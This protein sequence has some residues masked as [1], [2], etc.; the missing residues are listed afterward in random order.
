MRTLLHR[1]VDSLIDAP[2]DSTAPPN[3]AGYTLWQRY[4]ASLT[5][6]APA[7]APTD[8]SAANMGSASRNSAS[9]RM[10]AVRSA[11]LRWRLAPILAGMA[12]VATVTVAVAAVDTTSGGLALSPPQRG[13]SQ[14]PQTSMAPRSGYLVPIPGA[15]GAHIDFVPLSTLEPMVGSDNLTSGPAT[16][17]VAAHG[18]VQKQKTFAESISFDCDSGQFPNL[19]NAEYDVP[20]YGAFDAVVGLSASAQRNALVTLTF[21][22]SAGRLLGRPVH[23]SYGYLADVRLDIR[24]ALQLWMT[25]TTRDLPAGQE[26]RIVLGDARL[27]VRT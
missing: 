1:Y 27:T 16:I 18:G 25:C 22:D 14:T 13:I 26:V 21:T 8:L 7:P 11:Y 2:T 9:P 6:V 4:R 5:G 3:R 15:E 24:S 12:A 19:P 10:A 17:V 23:V 20:G